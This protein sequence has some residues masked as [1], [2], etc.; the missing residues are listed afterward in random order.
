MHNSTKNGSHV[1]LHIIITLHMDYL[2]TIQRT[3]SI[4]E[5]IDYYTSELWP[6]LH[7]ML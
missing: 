1:I 3:L 7:V 6:D 5:I 2:D 4:I